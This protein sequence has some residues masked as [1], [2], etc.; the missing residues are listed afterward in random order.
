MAT[1]FL[2]IAEDFGQLKK[3]VKTK[4][5]EYLS[6]IPDVFDEAKLMQ[7][8]NKF[9]SLQSLFDTYLSESIKLNSDKT[10]PSLKNY[11]SVIYHLLDIGTKCSHYIE[12]HATYFK[13][14]L[15]GNIIQPVS[16]L[17]LTTLI[18]DT[19]IANALTFTQKA[20]KLCKETLKKL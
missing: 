11:I 8:E 20:Q 3:I 16:E 2:N 18:V 14:S 17:D 5:S 4:R 1:S 15:F 10:L 9:H 13:P 6:M 12:R 7:F 19:F